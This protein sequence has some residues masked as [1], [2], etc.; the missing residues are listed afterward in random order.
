MILIILIPIFLVHVIILLFFSLIIK[1]FCP[2]LPYADALVVTGLDTLIN[3]RDVACK[4]FV[5]RISGS[6]THFCNP[7]EYIVKEKS[8]EPAHDY[9]LRDQNNM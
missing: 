4:L 6:K 3:R 2:T 7:V 9:C 5:H 1:F 8:H